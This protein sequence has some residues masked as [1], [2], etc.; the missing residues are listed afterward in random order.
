VVKCFFEENPS[1]AD[2]F[3]HLYKL[4]EAF[5]KTYDL[6]STVATFGCSTACCESSFSTVT[7]IN[8][9]QRIAMTH[10]RMADLVYLAF[11]KKRTQEIDFDLFLSKFNNKRDRKLQLY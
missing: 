6:F 4:R 2:K 8:R 3:E 7:A 10:Q 9:P 5:R 11:E 1:D